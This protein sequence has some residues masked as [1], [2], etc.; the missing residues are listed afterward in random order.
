MDITNK[1]N[2]EKYLY[3][4]LYSYGQFKTEINIHAVKTKAKPRHLNKEIFA[5][6]FLERDS[7]IVSTSFQNTLPKNTGK[8]GQKV[9][10]GEAYDSEQIKTE[11]DNPHYLLTNMLMNGWKKVVKLSNGNFIPL[12]KGEK[13]FQPQEFYS[14]AV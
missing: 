5:F 10:I 8:L 4:V 2:K 7:P 13:V 1:N 6:Q 9:Y 11:L 12:F 3:L 14:Q